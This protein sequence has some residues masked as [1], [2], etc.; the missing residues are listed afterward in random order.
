MTETDGAEDPIE[1]EDIGSNPDPRRPIGEMI[2]ARLSRRG[3]LGAAALLPALPAFAQDSGNT[4]SGGP[5]SLGFVELR[6]QLAQRDAVAEGHEI[7]LVIRWGDPILPDAP[8]HDPLH[9]TAEA[10]AGQFGYN[11][12]YLDFFP[13]PQGSRSADR[14][15][16]VV[17]HEYTTPT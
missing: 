16:L 10:Q 15:L 17:N 2:A 4:P 7:Q 11:N 1:I 9:Q 13:L 8:A 6:H 12:D 14:G 3:L 5:S